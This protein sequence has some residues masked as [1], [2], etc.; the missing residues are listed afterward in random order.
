[1]GC[2]GREAEMEEQMNRVGPR[3]RF[4]VSSCVLS[5]NASHVLFVCSNLCTG[6]EVSSIYVARV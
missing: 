4:P 1:V 6:L 3:V 5:C 2:M